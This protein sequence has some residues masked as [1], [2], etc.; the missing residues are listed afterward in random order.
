M[1]TVRKYTRLAV[2]CPVVYALESKNGS[3]V[4]F[5]LSRGGCAI[6]GDVTASDGE[7]VS[8]QIT[9]PGQAVP[10][11]VQLGKI[12]WATRREFGVDFSVVLPDSAARLDT[13]LVEVAKRI[14]P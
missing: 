4:V 13:F 1:F 6:E 10:V 14:Q 7:T 2:E 5:N 11:S 9:V 12:R 3:G 8:L